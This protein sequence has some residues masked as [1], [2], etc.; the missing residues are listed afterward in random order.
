MAQTV[1]APRRPTP[2]DLPAD[3]RRTTSA[4]T[5]VAAVLA[6]RA[7]MAEV[8]ARDLLRGGMRLAAVY[9]L[10]RPVVHDLQTGA[11]HPSATVLAATRELLD[12]LRDE[13]RSGS[14]GR[15]VVMPLGGAPATT[16]TRTMLQHVLLD[17]GWRVSMLDSLPP[18]ELL[19]FL[20]EQRD[21]ALLA[22]TADLPAYLRTAR[23]TTSALHR[24]LPSLP[25]MIGGA[26]VQNDQRFRA[27]LGVHATCPTFS[28]VPDALQRLTNPLTGREVEV[29]SLVADGATNDEIA[30]RLGI[31]ASTVKS[32]LERIYL[33]SR[34][35]DRAASVAWGLRS[36]W[37]H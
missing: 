31:G 3:A 10:L 11:H 35:G 22:L 17:E 5:L 14:R 26:G 27:S 4:D 34:S 32:H 28:S 16:V 29:L 18:A 37:I 24:E 9:D 15:I 2:L 6:G 13:V 23:S 33:K 20:R 30:E 19:P 25:L 1:L 21:L 7:D 8:A 12:R 36:G